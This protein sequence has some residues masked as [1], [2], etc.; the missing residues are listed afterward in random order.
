MS[1][2]FIT[3]SGTEV[4]K[5]FVAAGLIRALRR[6]GR[7]VAVLKPVVS[8][9]DPAS[10]ADSDPG[11]LL[12]AAGRA[13]TP[14]SVAEIAPWRFRA[15]LSP[16]LAARREQRSVDFDALVGFCRERT[17]ATG[18]IVVIEGIGGAMVPL[19]DRHTVLDW[20]M[21]LDV[22]AVLVCGSYLGAI[23]HALTA[24]DVLIRHRVPVAVMVVSETAGSTVP[25]PDTVATIA[26]FAHAVPVVALQRQWTAAAADAFFD[27]LA[28]NL[29]RGSSRETA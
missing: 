4:G 11:V 9:Y 15:S 10:A 1:G 24:L 7:D 29:V 17:A 27:D 6:T 21:K 12:A 19:D 2:V 25:L 13:V 20:M 16:D 22:P 18:D 23:S 5:T 8:G 3:A 26:R 14:A 28:A